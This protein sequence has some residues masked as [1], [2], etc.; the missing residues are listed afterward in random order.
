MSR[1][2]DF[3]VVRFWRRLNRA[4]QLAFA[5]TL[6]LGLNY[7]ASQPRFFMRRDLTA[8]QAR[9]LSRETQAQLAN[10]LRRDASSKEPVPAVEVFVT[11][12]RTVE[13]DTDEAKR[14]RRIIEAIN[15]QL[16]SMTDAFTYEAGRVGAG[17]FRVERIDSSRN[18]KV[19]TDIVEKLKDAFTP[20]T[21]LVVRC[22]DRVKAVDVSELFHIAKDRKGNPVLDGFRGEQALISAMLEAS[23]SRKPVVYYTVSHG[24]LSPEALT[25]VG[26]DARFFAELRARRFDIRPLSLQHVPEVPADADMVIVAGPRA[27]F[28]PR[29]TDKLR[30]YMKDRN[31]RMI[32]LLEPTA[33]HG[34]DELLAD[35]GIAAP[36]A[37]IVDNDPAGKSPDGDL[38]VGRLAEKLHATTK[39][40]KEVDLGLFA[41]RLRPVGLDVQRPTDATLVDTELFF[42][43]A[44]SWGERDYRRAPFTYDASKNDLPPPLSLGVAAERA[45]RMQGEERIPAGRMIVV[46][47]AD[48]A[49]DMRFEKGGNR[50]FLLNCANWLI[51]RN[52]LVDVPVRPL[53]E[54]K[55]NATTGDLM[56]LARRYALIPVAVALF[57]FLVHFWR[58]RS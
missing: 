8:S 48:I 6:V 35:W 24:E 18:A 43:S 31:G 13:G 28:E 51:D 50:Y 57:G 37:L 26:S 49:T 54:F 58:R 15:A 4:G 1:F 52:Y 55:L 36:D 27:T 47:T 3:R 29:E 32:A 14:Q 42:S 11:L 33:A 19:Y 40:L 22:G 34:L 17:A 16:A 30:R 44:N 21:A 23:D 20:R 7:L 10:I 45:V 41:G 9:S 25:P 5:F 2:D 38:F 12:P 39:I 46:G 53:S 56:S